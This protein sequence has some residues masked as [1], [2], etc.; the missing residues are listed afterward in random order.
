[1][2]R[3]S[4]LRPAR[5]DDLGLRRALS[6]RLLPLLVAAM[7]FLA[8]LTLAGVLAA[9]AMAQHWQQGAAA[10]LTVQVPQPH[11][12]NADGARVDRAVALLRGAPG[13]ARVRVMSDAELTDLLRPWLGN[14]AQA[15]SLPLPAVIEVRLAPGQV[16]PDA[17]LQARLQA[18]VPGAFMESHGVWLQRL[19]TLAR[20]LQACAAAALLLVAGGV[21]G[22]GGGGDAGRAGGAAG[23]DR[24]R[25][26]AGRHRRVHRVAL[27]Q[28]GDDADGDGG[29]ASGP[30][31]A[32]P[33]LLGLAQLAA[34]FSAEADSA[35]AANLPAEMWLSL[36]LLPAAAALI[37]WL[38]AHGTVRRWL[39]R[40][41]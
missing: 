40:L 4:V 41:P 27:R 39:R 34:P 9:A 23:R 19:S 18:A 2:A 12:A 37:G 33:V 16:E 30:A 26:W 28:S 31:V 14:A 32:L 5:F 24:D 6:D 22:G 11:V 1:M 15:M 21:G 29:R 10:V 7:T 17:D 3:R 8:A 13:M 35:G 38:T 20:S 36:P 25:A